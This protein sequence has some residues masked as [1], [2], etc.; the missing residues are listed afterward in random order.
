MKNIR[1]PRKS[2]PDAM[3]DWFAERAN[4]NP[5][6]SPRMSDDHWFCTL[7]KIADDLE[8]D[9]LKYKRRS[10]AT[11]R[12]LTLRSKQLE[13]LEDLLCDP[14]MDRWST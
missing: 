14:C 5:T 1:L 8:H 7:I 3:K 11:Q 10:E 9:C 4:H 2:L 12:E 6:L 13:Q